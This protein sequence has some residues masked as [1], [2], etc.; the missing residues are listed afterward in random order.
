MTRYIVR[1]VGQSNPGCDATC[2]EGQDNAQKWLA[3][4][5]EAGSRKQPVPILYV[6]GTLDVGGAECHLA[7]VVPALNRDR[8]AP[9]IYTFLR[10]G[11]LAATLEASGVLVH[12]P[13]VPA[14]LDG[15]GPLVCALRLGLTT[16]QLVRHLMRERPRLVHYFLPA[17]YLLGLPATFLAHALRAFRGPLPLR[18]MSR[19]SLN[20][21]QRGFPILARL[22]RVLHGACSA[23][24]GNSLAVTAELSA[25]GVRPDRL[26]LI[27]S[28]VEIPT[29]QSTERSSKRAVLGLREEAIVITQVAN[30]I[31]YKGHADLLEAFAKLKATVSRDLVLCLVGRDDGIGVELAA[32][33]HTL[34]V[35]SQIR[36]LGERK[37]VGAILVASDIGVLSSHQEGFS[38]AIL[39]GMAVGLPMVVTRVGGNSE[40]VIDCQ[41]GLIVEPRDPEGLADAL[42][43]L[44][45]DHDL[46]QRLGQA[47]RQRVEA[48]FSLRECAADYDRL[49]TSLVGAEALT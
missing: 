18:V 32:K 33:A 46:R 19:R 37:D 31:P 40:A 3:T 25:E 8:W 26:H 2:A 11:E 16:V 9:A 36:W 35:G 38:N 10:R 1:A 23:V 42:I 34:G 21:Y 20:L 45:I 49:Y 5:R 4:A 13:R 29:T 6:I 39:E 44:A 47:A 14:I 41:T 7:R 30:L 12:G 48:E 17:S 43:R 27:H 28:G 24:V 15:T 22:E